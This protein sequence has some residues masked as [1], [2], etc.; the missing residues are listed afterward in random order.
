[1]SSY[2]QN[3]V[4]A[5]TKQRVVNQTQRSYDP[6][7]I[8]IKRMLEEHT[9]IEEINGDLALGQDGVREFYFNILKTRFPSYSIMNTKLLMIIHKFKRL[10]EI[11]EVTKQHE[12]DLQRIFNISET[13]KQ[14]FYEDVMIYYKYYMNY[15]EQNSDPMLEDDEDTTPRDVEEEEYD[16]V[17]EDDYY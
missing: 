12:R 3:F 15:T 1:M 5:K 13:Q 10:G 6:D 7:E 14:G 8:M 11:I 9:K 16:D 2:F 17:Y 4:P